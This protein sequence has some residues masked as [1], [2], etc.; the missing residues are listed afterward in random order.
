MGRQRQALWTCLYLVDFAFG[1]LHF[2]RDSQVGGIADKPFLE[3]EAA[4]DG[5]FALALHLGE[6]HGVLGVFLFLKLNGFGFLFHDLIFV[7]LLIVNTRHIDD[8]TLF[9]SRRWVASRAS[10]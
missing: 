1:L 10:P 5:G 3:V 4:D 7:E 8:G 2:H 9:S 6:L